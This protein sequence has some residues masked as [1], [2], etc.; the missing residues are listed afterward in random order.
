MR[1]DPS[2]VT[3]EERTI[4][5][6]AVET[7]LLEMERLGMSI[8]R[9]STQGAIIDHYFLTALSKRLRTSRQTNFRLIQAFNWSKI[10]FGEIHYPKGW[11]GLFRLCP[12]MALE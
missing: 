6:S 5:N 3:A 4:F 12:I 11:T 2:I 8:K 9:T 7:N 10:N 1:I